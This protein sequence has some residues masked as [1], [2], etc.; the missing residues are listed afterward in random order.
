MKKLCLFIAFC[1]LSTTLLAQNPTYGQRLYYS[2]KV[3][4]FV[5]YYHSRVSN[6]QVNWDSV[7]QHTLP[8]IKSA[9]TNNEFNDVLDTMLMAAGPM[10]I[11]TTP[12]PDTL[13]PELKRNLRFGWINDPLF[14]DDVKDILDTIKNNFR[15]HHICWVHSGTGT[16]GYLAFPYDDPVI[17]SNT[18]TNYPSEFTR[19]LILFKYWNIINYFNPYN[20]VQDNPWD[21]T[22][23]NNVLSIDTVSNYTDFFKSIKKITAACNDAHVEGLTNSPA[24]SSY[25]TPR[26]ILRYVQNKYTVVKSEEGNLSKGD[27]IASID[28]KTTDQWED[29][30]R[31]YISAG[32][33]SVFRRFMCQY[34][35]FGA[36]GSR[37]QIVY[38]DSM[39]SDHSLSTYRNYYLGDS[40]FAGYYPN[41]TLGNAK[42]KKW[43]CNIGYVNMG[44]LLTSDVITMYSALKNTTAII[45]DIRNYPKDES[46]W[47]IGNLIYPDHRSFVK[48]ALPNIYYPGTCYW[49][50]D[51]L[52][53]NNNT[54]YY[55]GKVII[56]CNQ[57]TQSAAEYSCM[58]LR[59]MPNSV[60]IGSQT[61]GTDG[62]CS[63]FNLSWEIQTGFTSLGVYY[64]NGD[65]TERIGIVPDSIVYPTSAGIRQGRDEVLEKA[66]Q[67]AGCLVP[68][69][70]V[71][72]AARNVAAAAGTSSFT[73]TSNTNW[74]AVSDASWCKINSSGSGN[75][76]ITADCAENTSYQPRTA[77]IHVTVAGL[78]EQIVTLIQARSTNVVE[79]DQEITYQIYPNP[80]KGKFR[81]IP[82]WIG[83]GI[84]EISVVDMDGREI[85][86]EQC[87][88]EKG[89][90]INLS[91]A[92]E[93][94]YQII[95]KK[96]NIQ[97]VRKLVIIR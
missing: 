59:A 48:L 23:F 90:E 77:N 86:K 42:W 2:C 55:Q 71:T 15:P 72:P 43:N 22:L 9:V 30:L 12:S 82:A 26:I 95:I 44:K 31:P 14:R 94:I 79:E 75:G 89:C 97:V 96:D 62:D 70:S 50:H 3:W 21:S 5:K 41:D 67:A 51:F 54:N 4:G 39:D 25:Y 6:C 87:K 37:I 78:P 29:S 32:N 18:Y 24:Y 81:I 53:Q 10:E 13:P 80:T 40:W 74:A 33:P 88:E 57:E 73:V 28:G 1:T 36:G 91:S 60:V 19:L 34:L 52:G 46:P 35:L 69:L 76:T 8:L 27:I 93:G 85:L 11:A 47:S 84:P 61:A 58:I 56:L 66:L 83:K 17:D 45:F 20:Y 63:F 68:M 49:Y 16:S 7:L 65:S 92:P 38:K 64:P